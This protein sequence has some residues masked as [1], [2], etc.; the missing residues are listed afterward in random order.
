MDLVF[1]SGKQHPRFVPNALLVESLRVC[2]LGSLCLTGRVES[3]AR[4]R[5]YVEARCS[6]CETLRWLLVDNVKAGKT[7]DCSCKPH[8]YEGVPAAV[9]RTLGQRF[10]AMVQRCERD[11]HVS[12]AHY[13]GRGVRVLFESREHFIRWALAKWPSQSFKGLVFD[14]EDND[15]SYSPENLRLV[16]QSVNVRN[17][18]RWSTT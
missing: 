12:S 3:R 17:G 1:R 16:T 2:P 14:R 11:T 6:R 15:G 4:S 18:R 10:D 5:R 13:K 8:K 9:V 7:T